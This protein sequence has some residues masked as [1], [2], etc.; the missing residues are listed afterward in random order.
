MHL[1]I[2][3]QYQTSIFRDAARRRLEVGCQIVIQPIRPIF[4]RS[5][6]S[7]LAVAKRRYTNT[8]LRRTTMAGPR[9][10]GA[11][12]RLIIRRPFKPIFFNFFFGLG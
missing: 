9:N 1:V 8:N 7:P 12:A 2:D 4:H 11:P 3:M 6:S 5:S 10:V